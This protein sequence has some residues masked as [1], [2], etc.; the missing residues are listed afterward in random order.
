MSLAET[1]AEEAIKNG[2]GLIRA[3]VHAFGGGDDGAARV[4]A[5]LDAEYQ[6]IDVAIDLLEK[7][8]IDRETKP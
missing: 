1:L 6:A 5:I 4:R 3:V 7:E 2:P 8:A